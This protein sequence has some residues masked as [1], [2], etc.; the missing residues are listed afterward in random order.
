MSK[1]FSKF[2]LKY[3]SLLLSLKQELVQKYPNK[4][5][6]IELI[7]DTLMDKLHALKSHSFVDYMFTVYLASKEFAEFRKLIPT[8]EEVDEVLEEED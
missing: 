7:V 4:V 3:M 6:R 5:D 1:R 8:Q 2:K